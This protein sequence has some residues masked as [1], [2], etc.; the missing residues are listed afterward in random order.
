MASVLQGST[1][2]DGLQREVFWETGRSWKGDPTCSIIRDSE[3]GADA[4]RGKA[5]TVVQ[6]TGLSGLSVLVMAPGE[7]VP[8]RQPD[9]YV[10]L[11]QGERLFMF[12]DLPASG[13]GAQYE[14]LP[15]D[16]VLY[17]GRYWRVKDGETVVNDPITHMSWAIFVEVTPV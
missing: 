17:E 9:D 5:G 6:A 8:G 12:R 11:E 2:V 13:A 7:F 15:D 14:L 10:R 3:T 1:Y 16:Q 4:S